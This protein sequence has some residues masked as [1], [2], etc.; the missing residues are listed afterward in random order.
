MNCTVLLAVAA[1]ALS[2]CSKQPEPP[3]GT[4]EQKPSEAPAAAPLPPPPNY[5][6]ATARNAPEQNVA[7]VVNPFLTEQLRIFIRERGRL[8]ESF[9][10]LARARLDSVP[11]P[12]EGRKWVIDAATREV[13]AAPAQ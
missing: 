8:P 4:A 6:A 7:G 11:R 2:G 12:P 5:V 13:K 3:S 9:A 1:L 10:E